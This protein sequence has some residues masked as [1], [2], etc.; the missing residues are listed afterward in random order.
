MKDEVVSE[1]SFPYFWL[2]SWLICAS[3]QAAKSLWTYLPIVEKK[4]EKEKTDIWLLNIFH[5]PESKSSQTEKLHMQNTHF[6][7][8]MY[9]CCCYKYN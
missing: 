3:K 8:T 5:F 2:F 1:E 9:L 7:E 4:K 6:Q